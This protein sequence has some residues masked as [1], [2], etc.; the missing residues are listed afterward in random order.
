[1]PVNVLTIEKQGPV[2]TLTLN[3]PGVGN[4]IDAHLAAA[5]REACEAIFHDDGVRAVVLTGA[6]NHFCAGTDPTDPLPTPGDP[7]ALA[8]YRAAH[9]VAEA[10]ERLEQP[11]II[12][13]NGPC[14]GQGLELALA[15]DMRIAS[16]TTTFA[17]PQLVQGGMPWDGGTQRLARLVGRSAA[18]NLLFAPGPVDAAEARRI[19]LVNRVAPPGRALA[20]AQ[21]WATT[22]SEYGPLAARYTKEAVRKGLDMTLGQGLGLEADLSIILQTTHDRAEGIKS[23]FEKRKPVFRGE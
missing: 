4:A 14:H 10:V 2:V 17:M 5:L 11:I 7:Q 12:A 16:E 23:F 18:L 9:A 15:G 3:R 6:G 19:G 22:I 21:Q 1:M 8:E 20:E 13:V